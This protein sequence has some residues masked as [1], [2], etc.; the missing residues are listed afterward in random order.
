MSL[1]SV[2]A[3]SSWRSHAAARR[4]AQCARFVRNVDL[5]WKCVHYGLPN[6]EAI[7]DRMLHVE[8]AI[9]EM[10]IW[11]PGVCLLTG[12]LC[13]LADEVMERRRLDL[14]RDRH[15]ID[16]G[17]KDEGKRGTWKTRRMMI[18]WA[19]WLK[20]VGGRVRLAMTISRT[21][22]CEDLRMRGKARRRRS[23][24]GL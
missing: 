21:C 4:V 2:L 6:F 22:A 13:R 10:Q 23:P 14:Q 24:C 15:A 20:R 12:H 17:S 9:R 11:S 8:I 19:L 7:V 3:G 5:P 1:G 18:E 16:T